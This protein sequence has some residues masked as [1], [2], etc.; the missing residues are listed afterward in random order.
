MRRYPRIAIAS[1]ALACGTLFSFSLDNGRID[2][3]SSFSGQQAIEHARF[4]IAFHRGKL[5]LDGHTVSSGHEQLLLRA[6]ARARPDTDTSTKF[7]PL[8]VAPDYWTGLTVSLLEVLAAT[9]SA[10]ASIS[11]DTLTIRGVADGDWDDRLQAFREALPKSIDVR[12]D[13][14]V[15]DAQVRVVTMCERAFAAHE[16]GPVNFEESGTKLRSSAYGVLDQIIALADACRESTVSIVG[17]TDSSGNETLNQQ[18]SLARARAVAD[19]LAERG[20]ARERLIVAGAG[21]SLPVADNH[22]RYGRGLNRRIDIYLS[23]SNS[24]R[25]G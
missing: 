8:A 20:I 5:Q 1:A 23:Q 10:R 11:E 6:A 22:T 17:H 21:S 19:Y 9:Q 14:L 24:A 25:G 18:L 7:I 12:V 16:A 15:L 13:M 4:E 3:L 2:E